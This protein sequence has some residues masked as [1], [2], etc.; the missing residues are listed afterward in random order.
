MENGADCATAESQRAGETG[1]GAAA[2]ACREAGPGAARQIRGCGDERS[3]FEGPQSQRHHRTSEGRGTEAHAA[4]AGRIRSAGFAQ[5]NQ[6][7][8]GRE[9]GRRR[10]VRAPGR[11]GGRIQDRVAGYAESRLRLE[12]PADYPK[13][14]RIDG[15]VGS[16]RRRTWR[17]AALPRPGPAVAAAVP[18][19]TPPGV[20]LGPGVPI[21]GGKERACISGDTAPKGTISGG[22]KLDYDADTPFGRFG[23]HWTPTQ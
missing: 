14:R 5:R 3:V 16:R 19:N 22:Y 12:R 4:A 11:F 13:Y 15:P 7:H 23:C 10:Q 9:K 8:Y 1:R 18:A 6:S 17:A 2:D 20:G 21:P